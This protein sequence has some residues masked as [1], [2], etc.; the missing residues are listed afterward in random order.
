MLDYTINTVRYLTGNR[1]LN[2]ALIACITAQLLKVIITLIT[3]RKFKLN[4][5]FETGGMPSSHAA[6]VMALVTGV[7]RVDGIYSPSFA[8][9]AVFALI[10]MFDA[11]GVRRA[12]GEQAKIINYMMEHWKETTPEIFGD[13]L[14]ELLGHTPLQ[15]IMGALL[16]FVIGILPI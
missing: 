9:A 12:A 16:G 1:I 11:S 14:R 15:V 13:K 3:E 2:I 8:I 6:L 7:G 5:L 10:V 4:R